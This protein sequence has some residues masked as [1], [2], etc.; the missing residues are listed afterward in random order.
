MHKI[1]V[2]NLLTSIING[3]KKN[4]YF[5]ELSLFDCEMCNKL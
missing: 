1:Y 3:K 4:N 5:L 2:N